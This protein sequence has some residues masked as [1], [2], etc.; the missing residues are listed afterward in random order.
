MLCLLRHYFMLCR[1]FV[2]ICSGEEILEY[3]LKKINKNFSH[4]LFVSYN[5]LVSFR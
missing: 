5:V 1:S 3:E 2:V 4:S